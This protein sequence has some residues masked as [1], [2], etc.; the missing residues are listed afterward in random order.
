M[1]P[2]LPLVS[3]IT[4]CLNAEQFIEETIR[5]VINQNYRPLEYLIVDGGSTD[6]TLDIVRSFEDRLRFVSEPDQGVADAINKGIRLARG[7]IVAWL[8]ADD[9]YLPNAIMTGVQTLSTQPAA[10]AVYGEAFWI[11]A[12]GN[13]LGRYPTSPDC[14]SAALG[15][16]CCICQPTCFMWRAAVTGVGLLDPS[17]QASFD[18]D[19]W[20]RFSKRF[21]FAYVPIALAHSRMHQKNKTLGQRQMVFEESIRLLKRHY[22]YVPVQWIYGQLCYERDRRDQFFEPLRHSLSAYLRALP[23]GLRKNCTQRWRYFWEWLKPLQI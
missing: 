19:L 12:V 9:V 6:R 14:D 2:V 21:P 15:R 22:Q 3:I 7:D 23:V 8:N 11:D 13:V 16:E 18:Y 4:P 17:L 5:S 20:I 1:A 10:A